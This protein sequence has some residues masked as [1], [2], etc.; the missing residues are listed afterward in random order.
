MPTKQ[1]SSDRKYGITA[2]RH[3]RLRTTMCPL[4][5]TPWTWN[6]C[7]ARSKPMVVI[8]MVD[9]SSRCGVH[10]RP[11]CGISMPGR[12]P[13][14]P[15]RLLVRPGLLSRA[16][17]RAHSGRR[18]SIRRASARGQHRQLGLPAEKS[19]TAEPRKGS[20]AAWALEVDRLALLTGVVRNAAVVVDR[21]RKMLLEADCKIIIVDGDQCHALVEKAAPRAATAQHKAPRRRDQRDARLFKVG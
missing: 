1:G 9:G 2:L 17:A 5:S 20:L 4:A 10:R 12:G 13:S 3:S 16:A 14:T 15:S 18:A 11:R 8:C 7:L 6:Q 21:C 19:Y